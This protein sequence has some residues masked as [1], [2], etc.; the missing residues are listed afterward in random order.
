MSTDTNLVDIAWISSMASLLSQFEEIEFK[1]IKDPTFL[2]LINKSRNENAWSDLLRFYLDPNREHGLKDLFINSLF[3]LLGKPQMTAN[4]RSVTVDRERPTENRKRLDIVIQSD[5][6]VIGIENKVDHI[7]NNPFEEYSELIEELSKE[8]K[9]E[10][11]KVILSVNPSPEVPGFKNITYERLVAKIE[12]NL[13]E[14]ESKVNPVYLILLRDFLRNIKNVQK[15]IHM[16]EN[17]TALKFFKNNGDALKS[18]TYRFG[19]FKQFVENRFRDFNEAIDL[20]MV[21]ENI[22]ACFGNAAEVSKAEIEQVGDG[23]AFWIT[24]SN[25]NLKFRREFCI[26]DSFE[27]ISYF[28]ENLPPKEFIE[29]LG[30]VDIC[31]QPEQDISAMASE[32]VNQVELESKIFFGY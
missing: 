3:E 1:D 2:E 28:I 13:H 30:D 22:K 10:P 9:K 7:C 18:I 26:D 20:S 27:F 32:I 14:Y 23:P 12:E 8:T 16:L 15:S 19:E 29:R 25:G 24:M 31:K 4:H 5:D 11:H 6:F 21:N 17:K